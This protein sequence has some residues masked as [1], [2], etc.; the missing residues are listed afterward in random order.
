ME[1]VREQDRDR[2]RAEE[3]RARDLHVN[4]YNS[5]YTYI[6][7]PHPHLSAYH[8]C[9]R[10]V[11]DTDRDRDREIHTYAYTYT[12]TYVCLY[13]HVNQS[14]KSPERKGNLSKAQTLRSGCVAG[15]R[16][17][18]RSML[19]GASEST[20]SQRYFKLALCVI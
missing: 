16:S 18:L 12:T 7:C 11:G 13:R 5:I 4:I 6:F 20:G 17:N 19:P 14:A 10:I 9:M 1:R 3:E 2:E 8:V 15:M